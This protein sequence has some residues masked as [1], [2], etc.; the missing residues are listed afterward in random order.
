MT[1]EPNTAPGSTELHTESQTNPM[2]D[3]MPLAKAAP[4]YT[5]QSDVSQA[6]GWREQ[7]FIGVLV[8]KAVYLI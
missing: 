3:T 1:E 7:V 8:N 5:H 6:N 2:C 4:H